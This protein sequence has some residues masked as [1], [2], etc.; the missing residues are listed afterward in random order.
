[1][2]PTQ[3]RFMPPYP[4][5]QKPEEHNANM[6]ELRKKL[7]RVPI[8]PHQGIRATN[9]AG[10]STTSATLEYLTLDIPI[11][12]GMSLPSLAFYKEESWTDTRIDIS[13]S[14]YSSA[15]SSEVEWGVNIDGTDFAIVRHF[16]NP[17]TTHMNVYGWRYWSEISTTPLRAGVHQ[18]LPAWRRVSGAG[19]ININ[20]NDT[21]H[22]EATEVVPF[23]RRQ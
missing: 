18:I 20:V 13:A 3:A 22:I 6:E 1:M 7:D 16:F 21:V 10:T 23:Q 5:A 11:P 17:A 19:A 12:T 9:A 14:G 2:I 4:A 8:H 15:A